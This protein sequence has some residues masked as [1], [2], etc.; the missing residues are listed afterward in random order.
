MLISYLTGFPIPI[1]VP[2]LL[3]PLTSL[4][5]EGGTR[6]HVKSSVCSP[7]AFACR[8][9]RRVRRRFQHNLALPRRKKNPTMASLAALRSTATRRLQAAAPALFRNNT[10]RRHLALGGHSGP[11][12][13]WTGVD[14]IV[15]SYVPEDYQRTCGRGE[16]FRDSGFRQGH[17][18]KTSYVCSHDPPLTDLFPSSRFQLSHQSPWPF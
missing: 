18:R 3:T 13:E 11:A 12:P 5:F 2:T 14:K 4:T 17:Y 1:F 7:L 6:I 16:K 8:A 15:R 9:H 10:Q